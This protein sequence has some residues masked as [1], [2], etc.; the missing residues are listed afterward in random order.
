VGTTN[1]CELQF[2][3]VILNKPNVLTGLNQNGTR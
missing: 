3:V 1:I 2:N